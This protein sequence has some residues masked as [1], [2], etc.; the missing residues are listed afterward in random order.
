MPLA[1]PA[2]AGI[3]L[4]AQ[5]PAVPVLKKPA[6]VKTP[7]IPK[8]TPSAGVAAPVPVPP[9]APAPIA[10]PTLPNVNG[11]NNMPA[12]LPVAPP[13]SPEAPPLP[14]VST[15]NDKTLADL[16]ETYRKTMEISP[17]ELS[18]QADIDKLSESARKG[19]LNAENQAIPLEFIT[20]QM[21]AIEDRANALAEPL[22]RKLARLQASRQASLEGSK[23]ALDRAEKQAQI[24]R[25]ASKP[26]EV[27]AGQTVG[28]FNP[29]TGKFET[30]YSAPAQEKA[31][32]MSDKYGTGSIG[33]YNFYAEQ[34]KAAG[35]TPMGWNEYQTLDANRKAKI[36]KA[37]TSGGS[38]VFGS[39]SGGGSDLAKA[40]MANPSLYE[41]LTPSARTK[42]LPELVKM[43]FNPDSKGSGS[44]AANLQNTQDA[45][46]AVA[47]LASHPG[48]KGAVGAKGPSSL[49]GIMDNPI[50]GTN[51]SGFIT[52]LNR[53]K[54]LLTLP[55]LSQLRGLGAMS[56]REFGTLSSSVAALD[57]SM[58]ENDFKA[59]LA[60][61]QT[62]LQ[63]SVAKLS[64]GGQ[65]SGQSGGGNV[66]SLREKYAY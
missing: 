38:S 39:S 8:I 12:N 9:V 54:S 22:E 27:G 13:P 34:E 44:S 32:S 52:Q 59:E 24:A 51:A 21:K 58:S 6:P 60:R 64:G 36:A 47:A 37:G 42:I 14:T 63:N 20:G 10:N 16:E 55:A 62:V 7:V 28:R 29:D 56:D 43:G 41:T 25:D 57:R 18:T 50:A 3:S 33:E 48:L 4:A 61:I 19:F 65:P 30:I 66:N 46:S 2:L 35:R 53:V 5:K 26:M 1:L 11:Q 45:L 17:E 49:F 15:A 23:F 40:I 31:L